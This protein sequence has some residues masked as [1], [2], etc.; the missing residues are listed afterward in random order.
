M[1]SPRLATAQ[2]NNMRNKRKMNKNYFK[3]YYEEIYK[4]EDHQN[5]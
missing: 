3:N 4:K 5:F 1:I 2:Q